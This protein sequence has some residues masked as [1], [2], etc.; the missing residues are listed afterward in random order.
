MGRHKKSTSRHDLLV[1][2]LERIL[3]NTHDYKDWWKFFEYC[4][5]GK[6]GRSYVG[7]VDLLAYADKIYDFYEVK[8]NESPRSLKK[9]HEQF[10]RYRLAFPNHCTKGFIYSGNKGLRRLG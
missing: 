8:C 3:F 7:E 5:T 6:D 2:D 1:L 4:R 9:A 10:D